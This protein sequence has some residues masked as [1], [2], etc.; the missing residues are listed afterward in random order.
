MQ[1]IRG[2]ANTRAGRGKPTVA[3]MDRPYV[4]RP[5]QSRRRRTAVGPSRPAK[6]RSMGHCMRRWTASGA[7]RDQEAISWATL[8]TLKTPRQVATQQPSRSPERSTLPRAEI[9]YCYPAFGGTDPECKLRCAPTRSSTICRN[10]AG[11]R[12]LQGSSRKTEAASPKLKMPLRLS[13]I[14]ITTAPL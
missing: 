14:K 13:S 7:S 4:P 2:A 12:L 6:Q 5:G 8:P 10:A 1:A 11:S 3:R 9:S